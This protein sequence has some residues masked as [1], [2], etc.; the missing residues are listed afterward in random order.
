MSKTTDLYKEIE[1]EDK[2]RYNKVLEELEELQF[3]GDRV[4]CIA[5]EEELELLQ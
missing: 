1:Q 2:Q 3:S 4:S 5:K